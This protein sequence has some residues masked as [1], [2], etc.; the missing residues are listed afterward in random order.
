MMILKNKKLYIPLLIKITI[1]EVVIEK[2]HPFSP[3]LRPP[4]K[5]ESVCLFFRC[6]CRFIK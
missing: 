3:A 1:I 5:S 4:Q 2:T 6:K